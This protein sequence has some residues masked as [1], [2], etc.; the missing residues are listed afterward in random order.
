[1]RLILPDL[2]QFPDYIHEDR[3]HSS[4]SVK[5]RELMLSALQEKNF[6]KFVSTLPPSI[7][8]E[9]WVGRLKTHFKFYTKWKK[10]NYAVKELNKGLWLFKEDVHYLKD[11]VEKDIQQLCTKT[12]WTPPPGT[13]DRGCQVPHLVPYVQKLFKKLKIIQGASEYNNRRLNVANVFL[14]I[15]T[16]T[17]KHWK[18]F[19]YDAV[20]TPKYTNAHI[21]PKEDVIKAMIYL[22]DVGVTNGP[23][24]Y[25][26]D[27]NKNTLDPLQNIFGRA[28]STGSYCYTPKHRAS[29][30]KLPSD[31]R[32][33]HNF[34]RC[35]FEKQYPEIWNYLEQ[36]IKTITSEEANIM[37]FDPGGGIHQGALT[38][39]GSRIALQVLMK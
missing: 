15:S 31:L 30:F 34:G 5:D 36:N 7:L 38:E 8:T 17:D 4:L 24:K 33:S 3:N 12:D 35:I 22:D 13:M 19:F 26:V 1:M 2:A 9:D 10:P 18:Q 39:T 21:D 14:H 23:F 32:V 29:V 27:S 20:S 37:V 6:S 25:V 16:P 11:L 28:I